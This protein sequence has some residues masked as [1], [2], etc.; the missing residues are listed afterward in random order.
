MSTIK[1]TVLVALL[2]ASAYGI[3]IAQTNM[4]PNT[5]LNDLSATEVSI[6]NIDD[7][8]TT[9]AL[10]IN[11][12]SRYGF[13]HKISGL[14]LI[15]EHY[16][17]NKAIPKEISVEKYESEVSVNSIIIPKNQT[18]Y[19]GVKTIHGISLQTGKLIWFAFAAI[20]GFIAILL[21]SIIAAFIGENHP[22]LN[23]LFWYG[24][25]VGF[26]IG[27]FINFHD[28]FGENEVVYFDNASNSSYHILINSND[29]F[30]IGP[31]ENIAIYLKLGWNSVDISQETLDGNT[32]SGKI[33]V[34]ES[35][36]Y[37]V[38]NIDSKNHYYVTTAAWE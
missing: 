13:I 11:F 26:V 17:F 31:N 12:T 25:G 22:A 34:K 32:W 35:D 8:L 4:N 9:D 19:K 15:G 38:Y 21:K 14:P 24:F 36:G 7:D 20:F 16:P 10:F 23:N 33:L 28:M 5:Q 29:S 6:Y 27:I 3:S 2:F 37:F 1:N 18:E 30:E